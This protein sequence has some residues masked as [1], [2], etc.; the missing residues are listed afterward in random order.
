M[1][2]LK[3]IFQMNKFNI[4]VIGDVML[5]H[6]SNHTPNRVSPEAPVMILDYQ[7]SEYRLGAAANVATNLKRLGSNPILISRFYKSNTINNKIFIN[8]LKKEKIDTNFFYQNEGEVTLKTRVTSNNNQILR[9]DKNDYIKEDYSEKIFKYIK[10]KIKSLDAIIISDYQKGFV[11]NLGKSIKLSRENNVPI[12]VDSKGNKYE[13][14][15]NSFCIKP[16][17]KEFEN[18]VGKIISKKDLLKKTKKLINE[19]NIRFLLLTMGEKG[20]YLF[21]KNNKNFEKSQNYGAE[22]S[23]VTGAGDTVIAS[24]CV[25]YLRTKNKVSSLNVAAKAASISVSKYGTYPV[26]YNEIFDEDGKTQEEKNLDEVIKNLKNQKKKIVM[27]NGCYDIIH[28]GHIKFLEEAKKLGDIL[29]VALNS[30]ESVKMNKGPNRPINDENSREQIL[31]SIRAVD[32]VVKFNERTPLRI[33]K[34]IKPNFLV[35]GGD[36]NKIKIVGEDFVKKY[37]G[38]VLKL[39][40]YK[41]YS[42]TNLIKKIKFK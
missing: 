1:N 42:T 21:E 14:F 6:Y 13:N 24:F 29:I 17:L 34:K 27:T 16:N 22:V 15:K 40:Y 20:I 25:N 10:K 23:D 18:I 30:D 28:P 26:S 36:Y 9:I 12:F 3:K 39:D 7:S 33:I 37:G 8:L 32:I 4:L 19:L 38:K 41:N 11:K 2:A 5:D 35:K 31:K